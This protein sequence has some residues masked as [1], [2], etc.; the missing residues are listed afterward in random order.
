MQI[1]TG[2]PEISRAPWYRELDFNHWR[3][4][5]ASFLGWI[6]DGYEST[7]LF[8]VMVPALR[9]LLEPSQ[10]PGLSRYAGLLLAMTLLG[11]A[12]GG[13][14]AGILADY[15]GRK[16]MMIFTILT[17]AVF[18][19]LTGFSQNWIQMCVFRFL[20]GLGLGGEW[21]TGTTLLA[22]SWP[23]RARAKGLGIMQSAYGWGSLAASAVWYLLQSFGGPAAW[24]YLFFIGVL[25]AF[26]VLYIR[27]HVHESEK[28][29]A[30]HALRKELQTKQRAGASLSE[31]EAVVAN[32]TVASILG[33]APLRRSMLKCLVMSLGT[34]LG[35]WAVSSW[36]PSYVESVC[37]AGSC[38]DPTRW[39]AIAGLLYNGGAIVGYLAGGFL[40]DVIG[41][42]WLLTC[43]F[44][45]SLLTTPLLYLWT[46]SPLA[47]VAA[48]GLNGAF[49]LGQFVWIAIYP[50][51]LFPTAVRATAASMVFDTSRFISFLGPLFAGML[52]TRLGGYST[53]AM[54]LSLVYVPALLVIPFLPETKGKPLPV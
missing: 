34:T 39:S 8:L 54:L 41:R 16:R 45:G 1:S 9:Q 17:Y 40:A 42:R 33:N 44:S 7:A 20:T 32:F 29:E 24:R 51:E 3:V 43:F 11:W 37:R 15:V 31:E 10:L 35:Y 48:A 50:Q 26:A 46:H 28:W 36:V 30:R 27:R 47:I 5:T 38:A 6:F 49:T 18:T 13:V 22:E 12:T 25:P 53:T 21:A 52:I 4:L 19:G 23:L 2:S 14:L